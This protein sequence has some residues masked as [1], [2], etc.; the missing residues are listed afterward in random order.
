MPFLAPNGLFTSTEGS[1]QAAAS[2]QKGLPRAV[3]SPSL[4]TGSQCAWRHPGLGPTCIGFLTPLRTPHS[5]PMPPPGNPL[6]TMT[7]TCRVP[8]GWRKRRDCYEDLPL[9]DYQGVWGRSIE[10]SSGV[11]RS[12]IPQPRPRVGRAGTGPRP[13]LC[14]PAS[15]PLGPWPDAR[16]YPA[17]GARRGARR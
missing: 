9:T 17:G 13:L 3:G 5:I 2:S 7:E 12:Y 15:E 8:R 4:G 11:E 1:A 14:C 16:F 6:L 10:S